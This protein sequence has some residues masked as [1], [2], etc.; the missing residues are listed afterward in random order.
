ME[1]LST[2][3]G[4]IY[5]NGSG[6]PG[7]QW[8]DRRLCFQAHD[9][10]YNCIDKQDEKSKI[11]GYLLDLNKFLCMNELYTYETY[12]PTEVIKSR[13]YMYVADKRDKAMFTQEELDLI[14]LRKNYRGICKLNSHYSKFTA[15]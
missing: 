2:G 6:R 7:P 3:K 1:S 12:C 13:K 5:G 11:Y 15:V 10:Y 8:W 4:N 14:N 9:D